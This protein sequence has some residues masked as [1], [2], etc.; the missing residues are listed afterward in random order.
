M[1]HIST[2]RVKDLGITRTFGQ[3][4]LLNPLKY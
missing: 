4:S 3:N 1:N 2:D